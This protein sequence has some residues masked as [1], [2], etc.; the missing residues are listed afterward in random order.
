MRAAAHLL[1]EKYLHDQIGDRSHARFILGLVGDVQLVQLL[2]LFLE[3]LDALAQVRLLV[4]D[5]ALVLKREQR[6]RSVTRLASA[7]ALFELAQ[8][9]LEEVV[10]VD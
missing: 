10:L 4:R 1:S 2:I 9:R 8:S 3:L 7:Y 6:A 5:P